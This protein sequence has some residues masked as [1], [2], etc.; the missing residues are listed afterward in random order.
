MKKKLSQQYW[1]FAEIFSKKV[2][3]QL[4][5]HKNKVNHNIILEEVNNLILSSLYSM[6]LKQLKLIK[7]YLENYLKKG[8]IVLSDA[9]YT[10]S[11]LFAKKSEGEWHFCIDCWKLNAIIKKNTYLL[12]LIEKTLAQLTR[13]KVFI[14]LD[15]RQVFYWIWMK[16]S[17]EN[18]IIFHIRYRFYKYKVLF[19]SLCNSFAFFQRYI[20]NVLFNYLN[21][22]CTVYVNN[23]LIYSDNLLKH[24]AQVKKM[25]QY[26]KKADLQV[27]IKKSKFSVQSIKFLSF[28]ISTEDIAMNFEK[29]TVVKNWSVSKFVKEIQFFL[30][31]CN[32]YCNSLKK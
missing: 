5:L 20:N 10:S 3:N 15:V 26:F 2:S 29:I 25:L 18:L 32:F 6:S 9:L 30:R 23:I 14:K 22:F 17:V 1:E 31:F 24:N 13:A 28:I 7:V 27:N 11:V 12:S 19:F 16:K 21:N 4:S 8:F